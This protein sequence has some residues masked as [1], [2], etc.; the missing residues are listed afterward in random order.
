LS[1][2][3]VISYDTER[4]HTGIDIVTSKQSGEAGYFMLS[5]TAGKELQELESGMDYIFVLD[6]SGSMAHEGKLS[7]SRNAIESFIDALGREDRFEVMTFNTQPTLLFQSLSDA[8]DA[9][10]GAAKDFLLSQ[11]ARGGTVL[12]PA[13]TTAYKYKTPDRPLM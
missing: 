8:G 6:I 13:V 7:L 2:D 3:V 9:A 12:R 11:R 5:M 10:K 1:R 4:P